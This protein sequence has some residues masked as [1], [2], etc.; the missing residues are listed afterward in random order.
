MK[1]PTSS[2]ISESPYPLW[3][4]KGS[5]DT[6][7]SGSV[8]GRPSASTAALGGSSL[9]SRFNC[10]TRPM[11]IT[12]VAQSTTIGKPTAGTV[13]KPH[14]WGLV[15]SVGNTPLKGTTSASAAVQL[16]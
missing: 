4:P 1:L 13:G 16:V 9:P 5:S 7:L 2:L 14:E 12:D 10:W 11:A 15:P 8:V 6:A 3:S